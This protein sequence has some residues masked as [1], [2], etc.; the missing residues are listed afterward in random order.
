M[1]WT[2]GPA[3]PWAGDPEEYPNPNADLALQEVSPARPLVELD[4]VTIVQRI[5]NGLAARAPGWV[6][7]DANLEVWLIEEFSTVAAELRQEAVTVPEAI[8]QTYGEE[9][10]G[11]PVAVPNPSQG[12]STWTAVPC[13]A[14][15]CALRPSSIR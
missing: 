8:F 11:I 9:V 10:L 12:V 4:T 2:P 15:S 5:M 13:R 3:G 6:A 1:S 7:S 14:N